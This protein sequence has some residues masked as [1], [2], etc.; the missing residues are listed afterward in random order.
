MPPSRAEVL[1]QIVCIRIPCGLGIGGIA[2]T[3]G[4]ADGQSTDQEETKE[5][6]HIFCPFLWNGFIVLTSEAVVY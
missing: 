6:F 3:G 5:F 1:P 4:K 2:L